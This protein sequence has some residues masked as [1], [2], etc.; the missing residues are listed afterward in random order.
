M[1]SFDFCYLIRGNR[2]VD[3]QKDCDKPKFYVIASDIT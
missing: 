3:F 1:M 2:L